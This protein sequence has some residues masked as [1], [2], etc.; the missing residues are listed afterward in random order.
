VE[1]GLKRNPLGY[2]LVPG[3]SSIHL[4]KTR[5]RV[6]EG[7][8]VPALRMWFRPEHADR[9]VVKLYV[10]PCPPDDMKFADDF[11]DDSPDDGLPF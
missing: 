9:T 2:P 3:L 4:A 1:Y 8:W 10:E 6:M 5:L 11:W 7:T